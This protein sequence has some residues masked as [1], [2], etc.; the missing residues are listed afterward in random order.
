MAAIIA[1]DA[2][3]AMG[4]HA[5]LEV[6]AQLPFDEAGNR[7]TALASVRHE[8]LELF[9]NH[10]I[11]ESLLRQAPLVLCHTAPMRDRG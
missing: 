10:L 3:E 4:K 2:Q 5:A 1:M 11:E 9:G 8:R 6:C 7:L